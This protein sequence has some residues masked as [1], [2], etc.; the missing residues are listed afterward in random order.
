MNYLKLNKTI[1]IKETTGKVTI[2]QS[3]IFA[4]LDTDFK[5]WNTDVKEKPTKEI[6]G[7]IFD[8][9]KNGT[10]QQMFDD[11]KV[12]FDKL[13]F[14]QSQ[15]LEI[16]K[17]IEDDGYDY[18]F[19]FKVKEK[20]FVAGVNR[21]EGRLEVSAYRLSYDFVWLA[22]DRLRVVVPQLCSSDTQTSDSFKLCSFD[23]LKNIIANEIVD[24]C[25]KGE[26][27]S[28]LTRIYQLITSLEEQKK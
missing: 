15:I 12:S 26:S 10:F 20:F 24:A 27:T 13:C 8:L 23:S 19:L 16:A 28:R 9:D 6:K 11:F 3:K 18:F 7:E 25:I 5:N 1:D 22:E 17:D 21:H 14:T 2:T 4:Y